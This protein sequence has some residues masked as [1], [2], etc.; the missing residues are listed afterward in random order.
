MPG[1][2]DRN[3]TRIYDKKLD[4]LTRLDQM[5][6]QHDPTVPLKDTWEMNEYYAPNPLPED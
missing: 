6:A 2:E 1:P 3:E 5:H 4:D